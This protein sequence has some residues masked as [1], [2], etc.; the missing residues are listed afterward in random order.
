M[1]SNIRLDKFEQVKEEKIVEEARTK[2][3]TRNASWCSKKTAKVY[4]HCVAFL[5]FVDIL[6][7]I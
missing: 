7:V 3:T 1:T 5:Y 6:F 2:M 4:T